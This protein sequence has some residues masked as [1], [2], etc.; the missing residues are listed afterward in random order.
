MSGQVGGKAA[1]SVPCSVQTVSYVS[2]ALVSE[3]LDLGVEQPEMKVNRGGVGSAAGTA[4]VS[5]AMQSHLL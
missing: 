3:C 2:M 4:T 1:P 5:V